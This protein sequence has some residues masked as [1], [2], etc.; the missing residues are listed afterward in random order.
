MH[1][2]AFFAEFAKTT[3][4]VLVKVGRHCINLTAEKV[5]GAYTAYF[6]LLV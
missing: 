5:V 4:Y 6:M 2:D 1:I 3:F